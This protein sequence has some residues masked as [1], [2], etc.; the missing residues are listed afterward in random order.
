MHGL[1]GQESEQALNDLQIAISVA[2]THI[3]WYQLTIEPNT[4]FYRYPPQLPHE[5]I[6]E[7]FKK[8]VKTY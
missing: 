6:L 8:T 1:P 3:S 2:P 7:K 5:A 4:T